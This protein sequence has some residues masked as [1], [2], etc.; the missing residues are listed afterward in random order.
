MQSVAARFVCE[1]EAEIDGFAL[2]AY[3]TV[4]AEVAAGGR[5]RFGDG[6]YDP[7]SDRN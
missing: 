5:A 1:R 2:R 6:R 4:G 3:W 7:V